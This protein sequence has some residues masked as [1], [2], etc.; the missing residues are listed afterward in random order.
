MDDTNITTD[1]RLRGMIW[2]QLVGDAAA[3]GSHWIYNLSE[4]EAAYPNGI[5]GFETP[6]AG[7]YHAG[8]S[9]GDFTHYGD[10]AVILLQSIA[11]CGRFEAIHFGNQFIETMAPGK[12]SGYIDHATR[13]TQLGI[14]AIPELWRSRLK[15]HDRIHDWVEAIVSL[16]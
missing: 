6:K 16:A 9:P 14:H 15:D 5:H 4:L 7:H 13:G 8:K 2:G 11:S 3:L 10:A 1:D 12:Y